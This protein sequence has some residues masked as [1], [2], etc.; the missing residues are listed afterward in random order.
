MLTNTTNV[1]RYL[2]NGTPLSTYSISFPYWDKSE[3]KVYLTDSDGTL[4]TLVEN[5][6]YTLSTPN[7][8]NGTLTRVG[9]WTVGATNLTIAREMPLTQEVD[10]RNGDKIDAETLEQSLDNL[11]AQVQQVAEAQSR[12]FNTPIDEAGSNFVFPNKEAR[13]GSGQGTIMGFG[14]TGD[15]II[16][17]DLAGFDADVASAASNATAAGNAKDDAVTAK[18]K[19]QEWATKFDDDNPDSTQ[20]VED[21]LYSSKAYAYAAYKHVLE[22]EGYA[23][24]TQNGSPVGAGSPYYN[25]SAKYWRDDA[26]FIVGNKADKAVPATVNN[27]AGLSAT[28]DLVDTGITKASVELMQ[29]EINYLR[30]RGRFLSLWDCATGAPVSFP[31]DSPYSYQT[32]DYFIVSN[33]DSATPPANYRPTGSSYTTGDISTDAETNTVNVND[34][35]YYDGAAWMLLCGA[36]IAAYSSLV[37]DPLDSSTMKS[38]CAMLTGSSEFVST[39]SYSVGDLCIHDGA[40]YR[41]KVYMVAGSWDA[42][43]WEIVSLSTIMAF[44]VQITGAFDFVAFNN[45]SEGDLVYHEGALYKAKTDIPYGPWNGSNWDAYGIVDLRDELLTRQTAIQGTNQGYSASST[46]AVGDYVIYNN[47][48]YRCI[49]A[50]TVAE[51]FDSDKWQR[52]DLKNLDGSLNALIATP[53]SYTAGQ[54]VSIVR[55]TANKIGKV[56]FVS[57]MFTVSSNKGYPNPIIT[58]DDYVFAEDTDFVF[59]SYSNNIVECGFAIHDTNVLAVNSVAVTGNTYVMQFIGRIK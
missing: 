36:N 34:T 59:A 44:A 17:R 7:G 26:A 19:A 32:G 23:K 48:L 45:Y 40:L 9:D 12:A 55:A 43:K 38:L 29:S 25:D 46:Y 21:G 24:G 22:A 39:S 4:E 3:I 31:L 8:T 1:N 51:S 53:I 50:V 54:D 47:V 37:G 42:S 58:L 52:V 30:A 33:V 15:T 5:T 6:N 28:G 41:A 11:T 2:I 27:I 16:L 57:L 14:S 13:Q 49:T 35:Y 20:P 10:L 56:V 18:N